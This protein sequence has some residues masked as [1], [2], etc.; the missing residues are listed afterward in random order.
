MAG[1]Q[2]VY[3]R[4]SSQVIGCVSQPFDAGLVDI[5]NIPAHIKDDDDI[6]LGADNAAKARGFTFFFD[7]VS[8][9]VN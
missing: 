3:Q 7:F 2:K 6:V 8:D 4:S 9:I 1:D 5:Q